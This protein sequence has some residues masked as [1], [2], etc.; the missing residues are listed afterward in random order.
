MC[1]H[2]PDCLHVTMVLICQ[3]IHFESLF[4][5][6]STVYKLVVHILLFQIKSS[7]LISNK[8]QFLELSMQSLSYLINVPEGIIRFCD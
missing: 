5:G 7:F 3:S 4:Y 8:R 6:M 2:V 1:F